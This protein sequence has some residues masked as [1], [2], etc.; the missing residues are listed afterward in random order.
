M[1][2][3]NCRDLGH[4]MPSKLWRDGPNR[5]AREA[6][7]QVEDGEI[8][9]GQRYRLN[10]GRKLRATSTHSFLVPGTMVFR[11]HVDTSQSGVLAKYRLLNDQREV[12]LSSASSGSADADED[13]FI[14]QVSEFLILHRPTEQAASESPFKLEFE[15]KHDPQAREA[16]EEGAC[17]VLDIRVVA[18][19]LRT[20]REA[21]RCTD[22]ELEAAKVRRSPGWTFDH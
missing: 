16:Q 7:L 19:P 20:A 21:L 17:P 1:P 15:Y 2:D 4:K 12:L 6:P 14:A 8:N 5:S 9:W 3:I 10:D 18:E 13:G 11:L 22:A